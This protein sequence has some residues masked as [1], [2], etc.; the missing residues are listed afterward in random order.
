MKLEE[1]MDTLTKQYSQVVQSINDANVMKLKLEG[2]IEM[3]QQLIEE[4]SADQD[5]AVSKEEAKKVVK[6]KVK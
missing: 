4:E 1:R 5:G 6:E 2:A 3:A